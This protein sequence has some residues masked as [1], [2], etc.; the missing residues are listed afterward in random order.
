M[1]KEQPMSMGLQVMLKSKEFYWC[2][3]ANQGEFQLVTLVIMLVAV[4]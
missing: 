4:N 2:D 1:K 3:A